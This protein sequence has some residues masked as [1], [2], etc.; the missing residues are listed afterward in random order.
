MLEVRGS[1]R[2]YVASLLVGPAVGETTQA[3][4]RLHG[5][6]H[7][8]KKVEP[9]QGWQDLLKEL[10]DLRS[11]R[12]LLIED[13]SKVDMIPPLQARNRIFDLN[14]TAGNVLENP[15]SV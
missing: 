7:R 6:E 13:P 11:Q 12:R 5:L 10:H 2:A 9:M 8:L 1:R 3:K 15:M 4:L 14:S